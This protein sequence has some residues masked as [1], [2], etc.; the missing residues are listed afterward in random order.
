M[1]GSLFL[2]ELD[3]SLFLLFLNSI[4]LLSDEKLDVTVRGKVRGDSSMSSE[5]S[6]S[7]L[8]GSV[9]LEVSDHALLSV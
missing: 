1:S 4:G 8:G 3:S 2:S 6:S 5:S 7:S 9:D